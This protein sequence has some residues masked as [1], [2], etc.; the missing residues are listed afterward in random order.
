MPEFEALG[1]K[2]IGISPDSVEK[3][4][5]F[6]DKYR[7]GV[8]LAADPDHVAIKDYDVWGPKKLFGV[9]YDGL[10]RTTFLVGPDGKIAGTWLVTRDQGSRGDGACGDEGTRHGLAPRCLSTPLTLTD[11]HHLRVCCVSEIDGA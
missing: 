7:L 10:I 3:H 11:H 2:V 9:H 6:R 5:A 1:A 4:C 8:T